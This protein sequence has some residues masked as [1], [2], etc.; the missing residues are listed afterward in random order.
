MQA[1]PLAQYAILRTDPAIF[2][3]PSFPAIGIVSATRVE[4]WT[5][6]TPVHT[7]LEAQGSCNWE[8]GDEHRS[9]SGH[10][11][12]LWPLAKPDTL[13]RDRTGRIR[14]PRQRKSE[15]GGDAGRRVRRRSRLTL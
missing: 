12:H 6:V 14:S 15:D 1:S 8:A 9:R 5:W 4:D 11:S 7:R 13:C 10:G 2:R 3:L